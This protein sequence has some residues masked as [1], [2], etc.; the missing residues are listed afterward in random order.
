M[1]MVRE[2][3]GPRPV[4]K[5]TGHLAGHRGCIALLECTGCQL[6]PLPG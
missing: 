2:P 4:Q 6:F 3:P 5:A 1:N